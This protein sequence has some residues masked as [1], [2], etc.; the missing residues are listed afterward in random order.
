MP[1]VAMVAFFIDMMGAFDWL[2]RLASLRQPPDNNNTDVEAVRHCRKE[3]DLYNKSDT[4][5]KHIAVFLR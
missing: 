1:K 5:V 4:S 3:S 2:K